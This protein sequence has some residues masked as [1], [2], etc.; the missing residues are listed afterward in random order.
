M[1][2]L[3]PRG[4]RQCQASQ[5]VPVLGLLELDVLSF[6]RSL[7]ARPHLIALHVTSL[8]Q[9]LSH[10]GDLFGDS[11]AEVTCRSLWHYGRD[12]CRSTS[13]IAV[14]RQALKRPARRVLG[15]ATMRAD[16]PMV[17]LSI[18]HVIMARSG[19]LV[20]L[21]VVLTRASATRGLIVVLDQGPRWLPL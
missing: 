12:S 6:H 18:C 11:V 7:R 1:T 8:A 17:P 4:L 3:G 2:S 19:H 13:L 9:P 15:T 20:T 16:K 14:V 5:Q 21:Q 10:A